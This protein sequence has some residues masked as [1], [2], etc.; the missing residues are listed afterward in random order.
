M[1]RGDIWMQNTGIV[2]TGLEYDATHSWNGFCY[3]GKIS[4]IVVLDYII[5]LTQKKQPIDSYKLEFE[6]LEDFSVKKDEEYIQIHQVKSYNVE[7]LTEYKDAIWLL[8]GKSVYGSYSSIKKTYLHAA[9][10]ITSKKGEIDSV[11]KLRS[12]LT[13]YS[14]PSG[15]NSDELMSALDLFKYI[16]ENG[17]LDTAFN[18]FSLY[19]YSNGEYYCTLSEVEERVKE[20]IKQYYLVANKYK[21]LKQEGLLDRYIEASYVCLLGYID[22]NINE[23]HQ[24]RQGSNNENKKEINFEDLIGILNQKYEVLPVSYFVYYLKNKIMESFNEYYSHNKDYIQKN[25]NELSDEKSIAENQKFEESLEEVSNIIEYI[26][27]NYD[28]ETFMLFCQKINP[29]LPIDLENDHISIGNLVHENFLCDP[30]LESLI[31]FHGE[32]D[33]ENFL[34]SLKGAFYLTSTLAHSIPTIFG[35]NNIFEKKRTVARIEA[36]ISDF[37]INILENKKIYKV[38]YNVDSIITGNI[39]AKSLN[40][41]V[42]KNTSYRK[43]E[44]TEDRGDVNE[45]HHIM[46]IKNI[47]LI[48]INNCRERRK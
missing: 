2:S 37:A 18:K 11:E 10:R 22:K 4:L 5:D 44:N 1:R 13:T 43:L 38:L 29:H 39:N 46:K 8:L 3:Q 34:V 42:Y 20:K 28:D 14:K 31:N 32:L 15:S 6:Y 48:D 27:N 25:Y 45:S 17:L 40:E 21:V 19:K 23:R 16:D 9:E 30:W 41:Y 35:S 26:M 36:A 12:V 33:K 47:E 24:Q 7:S